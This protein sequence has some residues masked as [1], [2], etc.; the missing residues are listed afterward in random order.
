M[1][2]KISFISTT[3]ALLLF[4]SISF[5]QTVNLGILK[6]FE[7]YTGAGAITNAGGTLIG[8]VGSNSLGPVAGFDQ[9]SYPAYQ[10]NVYSM[11]AATQQAKFDLLRLYIHLNSISVNF[12]SVDGTVPSHAATFG[13]G[14]TLCPGVYYIASAASIGG[15]LT[16]D[17]GG[18]PD[19]FFIVKTNGALTAAAGTNMILTGGAQSCNIFFLTNGAITAAAGSIIK[20]TLFSKL[21]AVGLAASAQLE[22]RMF[23]LSGAITLAAGSSATLPPST[24]TIPVFCESGCDPA[25]AVDVLGTVADFALF[26][27][28]GAVAN[29]GISGVNG[30]I[31]AHTTSIA[32]Y[33]SGTHIGSEE[34]VNTVT[35]QAADDLDDA[36][37]ALMLLSPTQTHTPTFIN[38]TIVPGVYAIPSAGTVSGTII[39]DAQGNPNSIFVLRFGAAIAIAANTNM[40]LVNGAKRCNIFWIGGAGGGAGAVNIGASAIV[41][42]YF[43]ANIGASNSGAGVFLAG[44]QFSRSGAVNTNSPV[45]YTNP[46]CVT[47]SPLDPNP[48]FGLVT[49]A[50]VGGTGTVGDV[51]TYTYT[52]SN[53]GP[54]VLT[55]IT[56]GPVSGLTFTANPITTLD[57]GVVDETIS[58][59]YTITQADVDAGIVTS[60][61][62][63]T[64]QDPNS[65][66]VTD[67]SGT[68]NDND[69][70]TIT[71]VSGTDTDGDTVIDA[72]DNCPTI[73]NTHQADQDGDSV[74]DP[75][76]ICQL[77]P[78]GDPVDV[79]GC[80]A[81]Q[82]D[83]DND[84]VLNNDDNCPNTP[85]SETVDVDGCS[86][87]QLD[88]DNDGVFNDDEVLGCQNTSA[89][90]YNASATDAYDCVYPTGCDTCSG[91]TD[92]TGIIV[93]GD[94]DDD[95][96]CDNEDDC[97]GDND[98]CGVCNG[99]GAIYEC[100][101]YD[102]AE[103]D[104][105]CDGNQ[106]DAL[107]VCAGDCSA[108][109]DAD[110]ICDDIDDCVGSYDDCDVC[111]GDDSSCDD[112]CLDNDDALSALGG[113]VNA[114]AFLGC[115]TLWDG[116]LTSE[117]CP[118]TCNSCGC[119]DMQACN[120]NPLA[121]SD[122]GSCTELDG[123]SDL[124]NNGICDESEVLGC[125]YDNSFNFD[126]NATIDDGTCDSIPTSQII[127]LPDGWSMF[128]TYI[129][130]ENT[131][132]IDLLSPIVNNVTIAK[133]YLGGAYLP[134]WG[135]NGIGNLINGQGYQIK[136]DT[137]R[138]DLGINQEIEFDIYGSY[139][140]TPAPIPLTEGWNMV[141]YLRTDEVSAVS[142]LADLNDLGNLVIAK[143]DLGGAYLPDWG[144]NGLGLM[145][146]GKAYQVKILEAD[147]LLFLPMSQ[148]YRTVENT[149][150][151]NS[152][153]HY[154]E[155]LITGNNMVI[156]IFDNA[157]DKIPNEG[158][159]L[160]VLDSKG[161]VVG[162]AL[163]TSPVTVI[164]VWG[165]DEQTKTKD[166]LY[167]NE[168]FTIKTW[169]SSLNNESYLS[170]NSWIS[171]GDYYEVDA[172]HQIGSIVREMEDNNS[173]EF[174]SCVPNPAN[175]ETTINVML[176]EN[177]ELKLYVT[178]IIGKQLITKD[179][180]K[181]DKGLN[182]IYL[183]TL[184]LEPGSYFVNLIINGVKQTKVLTI[185]K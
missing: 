159:E 103:Q 169:S 175:S 75:C 127:S 153:T 32:G 45:I 143:S 66:S 134:G 110:G 118:E 96:I 156:G 140:I 13:A 102:I 174:I 39:L 55:N 162:T 3:I 148:Q 36:Y 46:E 30:K 106:L 83:D 68:T 26:A 125:T 85:N 88:N 176:S 137:T 161:L 59:T 130:S 47:S 51:I 131:D 9:A 7:A 154:S 44:A 115:E 18:N 142:I 74:G 22:G 17:G 8:D 119:T 53:I 42:G 21:G 29:V 141:G 173:F 151:N 19:A 80:S 56:I 123:Y 107:G 67:T 12:P 90:N 54:A 100:G 112:A 78:T 121:I 99:P 108:D 180:Y 16:F 27:K 160:V 62:T 117:L 166:G 92:G 124:N 65:L 35:Q 43:F 182:K 49:T 135:F 94:I 158:N 25:P 122:D 165:N 111:N 136:T 132:M 114:I 5:S 128:S 104:C 60:S 84:S 33:A 113:C 52:V 50:S 48:A 185:I 73:P 179:K 77:T 177:R 129:E 70:S 178:N 61:F 168:S 120:Y 86:E 171:G 172:L 87:S 155:P 41:S 139:D 95:G 109:T 145:I 14:E 37:D 91:D 167:L 98:S 170:V 147:S 72:N 163:Y 31:G 149:K 63:A 11:N 81:S 10:G 2:K 15:N 157:W 1:I 24:S 146:P 23:S 28:N 64:G 144:F 58:A 57:I 164:T 4:S 89:C 38:E 6:S 76:D 93:N 97:F 116:I 152:S 34:V 126:N 20:G 79:D 101:C 183:D 40:V 69:D 133:D 71:T 82:A 105:D 150:I 181:L 138:A 184:K